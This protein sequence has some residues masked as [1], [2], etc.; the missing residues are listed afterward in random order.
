MSVRMRLL[1]A[2]TAI[3]LILSA[4]T[5]AWIVTRLLAQPLATTHAAVIYSS[6]ALDIPM[7]GGKV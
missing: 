2:A 3:G 4:A 1:Q 7:R 5:Q 6:P